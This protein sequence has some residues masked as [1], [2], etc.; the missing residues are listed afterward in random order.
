MAEGRQT[1]CESLIHEYRFASETNATINDLTVDGLTSS[2]VELMTPKSKGVYNQY[3]KDSNDNLLIDGYFRET[4]RS[5]TKSKRFKSRNMPTRV[6]PPD[7]N[8]IIAAYYL[9]TYS[10]RNLRT[11]LIPLPALRMHLYFGSFIY[12]SDHSTYFRH[13]QSA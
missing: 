9:K 5:M 11:K 4:M 1:E 3:I 6:L 7:V 12:H 13:L 8:R 10:I 2:A